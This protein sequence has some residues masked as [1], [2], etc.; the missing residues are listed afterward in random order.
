MNRNVLAAV[1]VVA[2]VAISLPSVLVLK[3]WRSHRRA[4]NAPPAP[5]AATQP[6]TVLGG[7]PRG[8]AMLHPVQV[9]GRF[10]YI[11]G[12]GEI[13]I[14]PQFSKARPFVGRW[15]AACEGG[16]WGV[17]DQTGEWVIPPR[18]GAPKE[19]YDGRAPIRGLG[20]GGTQ[21][22]Y[23][24]PSGELPSRIRFSDCRR[25]SGGFG[26]AQVNGRWGFVDSRGEFAIEPA[27]QDVRGFSE[28]LAAVWVGGRMGYVD[29]KGVVVIPPQ[30]DLP[31]EEAAPCDF[32]QGLAAV[33]IDGKWG[34]ID[35]AG[36]VAI[37]A[38]F[39]GARPFSE[40]LA[41]VRVAGKW[42]FIDRQGATVIAP[43]YSD[44]DPPAAEDEPYTGGFRGGLAA[45]A[46]STG[47]WGYV[48]ALG[49]VVVPMG[50]VRAYSFR[51]PLAQV[52]TAAGA[53][54]IDK[55]GRVVFKPSR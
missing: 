6:A 9:A 42:G 47:R 40:N 53:G 50:Y 38:T 36:K 32:S 45:V 17:I 15:A 39:E 8:D 44:V 3:H 55:A 43:A 54:Y 51:G 11:N 23:L 21:S 37:A 19:F 35:R 12:D 41:A 5:V 7:G 18:F 2:L 27:Y 33:R 16:R 10:G 25:Y 1:G 13:V 31:A 30:F 49:K 28:G 46:D 22:D 14:K 34:Y 20:V 26:P 48:D 4:A 24:T 52:I 29:G